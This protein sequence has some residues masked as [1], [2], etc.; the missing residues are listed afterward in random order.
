[1]LTKDIKNAKS[2]HVINFVEDYNFKFIESIH[3]RAR[4]QRLTGDVLT[5]TNPFALSNNFFE[6]IMRHSDKTQ[7]DTIKN[8]LA[9]LGLLDAQTALSNSYFTEGIAPTEFHQDYKINLSLPFADPDHVI[10][11]ATKRFEYLKILKGPFSDDD[12]NMYARHLA[13]VIMSGS[14]TSTQKINL[15]DPIL[16]CALDKRTNFSQEGF[17]HSILHALTNSNSRRVELDEDV[18][19]YLFNK[20]DLDLELLVTMAHNGLVAPELAQDRIVKLL[21]AANPNINIDPNFVETLTDPHLTT[22]SS[23]KDITFALEAIRGFRKLPLEGTV[24]L[25]Y[26]NSD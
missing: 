17:V 18:R 23:F 13:E 12:R 7:I 2:S 10:N 26:K 15:L 5:P 6:Q 19:D 16:I 4:D 3:Q 9:A 21:A 14:L 24:T 1:M 20:L 22:D 8:N 11:V 25:V